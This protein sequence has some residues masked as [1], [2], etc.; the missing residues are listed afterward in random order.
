MSNNIPNNNV[1]LKIIIVFLIIK[2]TN[3]F[4]DSCLYIT[5]HHWQDAVQ[6]KVSLLILLKIE[7]S[8]IIWGEN[9]YLIE[10]LNLIFRESKIS[11]SAIVIL[12]ILKC[13][14]SLNMYT[15]LLR[16]QVR[17]ASGCV[18]FLAMLKTQSE[19]CSI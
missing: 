19:K 8:N 12:C 15:F 1:Q 17:P 13:S 11:K 4:S 9:G 3:Q 5:A 16:G 14:F 6:L 18:I 7:I 10:K 2:L